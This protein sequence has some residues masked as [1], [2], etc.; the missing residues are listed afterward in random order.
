MLL[1]RGNGEIDC[2]GDLHSYGERGELTSDGE[3]INT[4]RVI[5]DHLWRDPL[6]ANLARWEACSCVL[7][8]WNSTRLK[9]TARE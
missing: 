3:H 5:F 2:D 6:N 9:L 4:S 7:L 1:K 8:I